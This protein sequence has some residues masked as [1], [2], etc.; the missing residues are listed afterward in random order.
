[1]KATTNTVLRPCCGK[2]S[3]CSVSLSQSSMGAV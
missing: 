3:H 1:M 2:A